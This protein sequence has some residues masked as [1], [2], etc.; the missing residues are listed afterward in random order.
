MDAQKLNQ[1]L[2]AVIEKRIQLNSLTYDDT[3][4]DAVEEELHDLEDDFIDEF[5]N[6]LEEV[7][8]E[9]HNEHCSDSDVLSP[10][11]YLGKTY[12][13]NGVNDDGSLAYGVNY[14]EGALV[15]ADK[16]PNKEARLVIL[17]SP[18]RIFLMIGQKYEHEVWRAR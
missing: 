10:I 7:L 14:N 8:Q 13:K 4:Y 12:I 18:V 16:F 9:V 2:I 6:E 11:A 15:E 17:P 3:K 5:G 1:A